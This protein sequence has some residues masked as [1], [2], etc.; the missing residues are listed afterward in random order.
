MAYKLI[1][2]AEAC[3]RAV[4]APHLVTLVR[5]GAVFQK[6]ELLE[7]TTDIIL[8]LNTVRRPCSPTP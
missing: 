3:W 8:P 5:A 7:R 1:D 4:D 6:S 2:A